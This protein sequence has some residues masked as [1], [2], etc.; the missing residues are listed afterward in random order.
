MYKAKVSKLW[1]P[2]IRGRLASPALMAKAN[3]K[4]MNTGFFNWGN[5]T[6]KITSKGFFESR[7]AAFV[8]SREIFSKGFWIC[9]KAK[10]QAKEAC[11]N[12]KIHF[13][14]EKSIKVEKLIIPK[15][16]TTEETA[17]GKSGSVFKIVLFFS[18]SIF[19]EKRL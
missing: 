11:I 2:K 18:G 16:K 7:V 14:G 5:I 10:G 17:I 1:I 13:D 8:T 4:A 3:P 19:L 15:P 9:C 6:L 12:I